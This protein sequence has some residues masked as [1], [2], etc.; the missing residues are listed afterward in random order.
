MPPFSVYTKVLQTWIDGVKRFDAADEDQRGY[1]D[2]GFAL[3]RG[4]K[5]PA[6]HG[7]RE[8]S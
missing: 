4:T 1:R 2:G 6:V 3:P 5:L 8:A 7:R